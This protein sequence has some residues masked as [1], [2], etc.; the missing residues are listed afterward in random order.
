M[1]ALFTLAASAVF[2]ASAASAATL[3]FTTLGN[4]PLGQ[5]TASITDANLLSFGNDLYVGAGPFAPNSICAISSGAGTCAADFLLEFTSPVTNVFMSHGIWN[6]LDSVKITVF[7]L[8]GAY[9]GDYVVTSAPSIDLS[10]FGTITSL[11]FD[12]SSFDGFDGGGTTFGNVNY[13]LANVSTVPLPASLPFLA[14]GMGALGLMRRR[15][16]A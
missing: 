13:T 9:S 14:I 15:K 4:G 7:G 2:A 6:T 16:S 11:F 10:S 12:D 1:K 8:L 3:D 5:T